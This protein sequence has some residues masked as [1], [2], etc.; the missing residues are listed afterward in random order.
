VNEGSI[1]N[2]VAVMVREVHAV[3]ASSEKS[4]RIYV[5]LWM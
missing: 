4:Q 5:C 2:K 3:V 1:K